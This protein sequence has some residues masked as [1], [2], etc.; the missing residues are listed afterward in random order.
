MR[1]GSDLD[2]RERLDYRLLAD[3]IYNS[4]RHRYHTSLAHTDDDLTRTLEAIERVA[5]DG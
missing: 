1:I 2:A 5:R 4:P 3:G